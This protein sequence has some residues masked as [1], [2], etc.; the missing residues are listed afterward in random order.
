MEPIAIIGIGCRFPGAN[1]PQEFGQLLKN[2]IDAI[3]EVPQNRWSVEDY[4]HPEPATPGKMNTRWGGFLAQVSLFDPSFFGISPREASRIDPQQRLVLE[5]SWE[6]LED[7]AISPDSLADS[8]TGVFIGIGNYDYGR[9]LCQDE[10]RIDSHHGT[11]LTLSLA[12][13]RVSY[14]LNLHGPSMAIETACSSSLV[15]VHTA[16]QNLRNRECEMALAGGVSLMLLPDMTITF[17]QA[18]MMSPDGR[19]KTF[20]AGA[21]GYVRGEGCGMLVLKR[22]SDAVASGDRILAVIRGSAVN[23]DGLSNG[24]TAPNGLAQQAVIRQALCQAGV[25]PAEVSYVEAHGTGTAL[26][27]PVE[28]RAL[29]AVLGEG[30]QTGQTCSI[31][32]VK[33]NIGHLEPAAGIAGL[34]KVVLSLQQEAI[35]PHLHVK[36]LNPYLELAGT[37][38]TIPK[39]Y[40]PWQPKNGR[41]IAGVSAFSFGG[42]NCHLIVE[43]APPV[44]SQEQNSDRPYHLLA[45]SAKTEP[46]LQALAQRYETF[47]ANHP[48]ASLGEICFTANTGRS[49]FT[50]RLTAV[51]TTTD[52]LHQQL[53]AF[54]R[55]QETPGV[56][57]G[58]VKRGKSPQ[59]AFL[60][61]GQ[62]SS[63]IGMGRQLYETEPR[64]RAILDHCNEILRPELEQPLLEALYPT[65]ETNAK[66]LETT[67][68]AQPALLAIAYGL[69]ELWKSFGVEPQAVLGHSLGEYAAACIAGSFSLEA[70]LKLLAQRGRL[71]QKLPTGRGMVAVFASVETVAAAIPINTKTVTIATL[72]GP[73]HTVISGERQAL[74]S[75]VATLAAQGIKTRVLPV[76]GAFHSPWVEPILDELEQ[77]ANAIASQAPRIP[78]VSNLTGEIL[79]TDWKPTGQYWRQQ[80]RNPVRF[81]AG[82]QTLLNQGYDL[83]VEIGS[84]SILS[85]IAQSFSTATCLPSLMSDQSDWQV[86]L[87]SLAS[88]YRRGVSVNWTAD[89]RAY[90]RRPLSLPTYPF[91]RQ[92][93]WIERSPTTASK[94]SERRSS[95]AKM[96]P[97]TQPER[98]T[99]PTRRG[100]I[101][102]QL[103]NLVG[104]LLHI[105]FDRVDP[106]TPFLEMGADSL[107]LVDAIR[108][109]EKTYKLK[110]ALNQLFAEWKTIDALAAYID[111][112]Q[113][114]TPSAPE[115]SAAPLSETATE[116]IMAQQLQ[117]M[118]QQLAI[119]QGQKGTPSPPS[120]NRLN[121]SLPD[122]QTVPQSPKQ[123]T[124]IAPSLS[125][126]GQKLT[127][128]QEQHLA[129]LIERYTRKTRKSKQRAATSRPILADSRACAGFRPSIKEM[130]YPIVGE[131]AAGAKFWDIDGN[132]YLDITMG[133]GVLLFGHNPPCI[134][135]AMQNQLQQGLQ[136]GPQ[137]NLAADVARLISDLTGV[138]RVCFCNSGTEAVMTAL[139][140]AR[141]ATG[142][143]KIALFAGSYH[144]HFDGVLAVQQPGESTPVPLAPGISPNAIADVLVL[145]YDNPDT[146]ERL[147]QHEQ[148]LA[149]VLVEPVPSRR[150]DIQPQAFWKQLRDQEGSNLEFFQAKFESQK[151]ALPTVTVGGT[152]VAPTSVTGSQSN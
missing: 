64:F 111:E 131:R 38:F 82:F 122:R 18:R 104:N 51:A 133:F 117:V 145:E 123:A 102:A 72:N 149:A 114:P 65:A 129:S 60:F 78:L 143:R 132:E 126:P 96:L 84:Q 53:Q 86:L 57:T 58:T 28:I 46:A 56:A 50:H 73:T 83:F 75:V 1:N 34:I 110:I 138:E 134:A 54:N 91:Q 9:L 62:G 98:M 119:L 23:H 97:E 14:F 44:T 89:G 6:A 107:V 3:G 93:Y 68:Y 76:A 49:H 90:T 36:Q 22:L 43:A 79:P 7:A 128:R 21:D 146:W 113:S 42:S 136:I 95:P 130:L 80:A 30:R 70:G 32:S 101:V 39:T 85:R 124:A 17:S 31:G 141:T 125:P 74:E 148:D 108:A 5:V 2:G 29:Q 61:P 140:L 142:R 137:S 40:Q 100:E 116:R 150:P 139:R 27:D 59:I 94:P 99:E 13:N 10:S 35:F 81:M 103:R 87:E 19:C 135:E 12:A 105:P 48:Q 71:M 25:L 151:V 45:I 33:T 63:Y 4:Y 41:R 16:C 115:T 92:H 24:L 20:D 127:R 109:I 147:Y 66:L 52:Q 8:Q 112:Q 55:G 11:G 106:D 69:S 118:S 67:A 152:K 144:G 26:G 88:L 47:L 77:A 120:G 37:P 121:P 15:A